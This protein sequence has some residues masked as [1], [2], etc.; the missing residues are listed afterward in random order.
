[1]FVGEKSFGAVGAAKFTEGA[2][3]A[4]GGGRAI[5]GLESS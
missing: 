3:E 4:E 2:A 1:L 5:N